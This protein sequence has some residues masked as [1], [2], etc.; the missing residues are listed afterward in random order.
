MAFNV[1]EDFLDRFIRNGGLRSTGK[2]LAETGEKLDTRWV[3][4]D[5]CWGSGSGRILTFGA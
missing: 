1:G 5:Q 2:T 3:Y 4:F